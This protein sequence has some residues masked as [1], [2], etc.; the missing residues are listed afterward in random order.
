MSVV[1]IGLDLAKSVVQVLGV[2]AAGRAVLRRR[3]RCAAGTAEPDEGGGER[4]L[5]MPYLDRRR[6]LARTFWR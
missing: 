2:D 5:A 3:G 1:M 4:T 6:A